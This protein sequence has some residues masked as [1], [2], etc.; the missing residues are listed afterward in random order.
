MAEGRGRIARGSRAPP[1]TWRNQPAV[2]DPLPHLETFT[3][4]AED[5]SFTAAAR[6]LGLTQ[7]AVSQ[8]IA[9]LE[10]E[11]GVALFRRHAGRVELTDAG[12]RLHDYAREIFSLFDRARAEITG[13]A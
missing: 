1:P 2:A 6:R 7:A 12:R 10:R 4:A 8:R 9:A 11:L 3:R 13:R 5:G